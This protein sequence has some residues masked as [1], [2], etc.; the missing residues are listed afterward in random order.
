[1]AKAYR[2]RPWRLLTMTAVMLFMLVGL[3]R[4]MT[5]VSFYAHEG[6]FDFLLE[7]TNVPVNVKSQIR[8][9]GGVTWVAEMVLLI[10]AWVLFSIW[11]GRKSANAAALRAGGMTHGPVLTVLWFYIPLLNIFMPYY[12]LR[13]IWL[14]SN[15]HA[16][17]LDRE[18]W[19]RRHEVAHLVGWWWAL[20]LLTAVS[21]FLPFLQDLNEWVFWWFSSTAAHIVGEIVGV[22]AV[23]ITIRL[24]LR[25]DVRQALRKKVHDNQMTEA[26]LSKAQHMGVFAAVQ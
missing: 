7:A 20:W 9:F 18:D 5:A 2:Y 1:M 24:L 25:M 6:T 4:V 22:L 13:E 17:V 19:K 15:P 23:L 10:P 21:P 16:E 8:L 26:Q 14:A 12:A 3:C 11:A